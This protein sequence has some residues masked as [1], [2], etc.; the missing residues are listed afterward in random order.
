MV[1]VDELIQKLCDD[2]LEEM[3]E[4]DREHRS[5]GTQDQP[6]QMPFV[7]WSQLGEE[8]ERMAEGDRSSVVE[9]ARELL[10][11]A[12]VSLQA[13]EFNRVTY[14]LQRTLLRA[15]RI[16]ADE[17]E[18][19]LDGRPRVRTRGQPE[20]PSAS[21]GRPQQ[22]P[23]SRRKVSE[24]VETFLKESDGA[25]TWTASTAGQIKSA[26]H[27][28]VEIVGADRSI[29]GVTRDVV[30]D[31][32]SKAQRLPPRYTLTHKGKS[33][34]EVLAATSPDS[35]KV[36]STTVNQWLSYVSSMFKFAVNRGWIEQNPATGMKLPT[37][38]REKREERVPWTEGDLAAVFNAEYTK[39]TLGQ[40]EP[41]FGKYWVPLLCL[42]TGARL[43]E[44]AQLRVEDVEKV[45]DVHVVHVRE[46]DDQS[47]KTIA[48]IRTVPL[49]PTLLELGFLRHVDAMRSAGHDRLFPDL[50]NT[51]KNKYGDRVSKFFGRWKRK[52]GID[53]KKKVLHSFRNTVIDQLK[54]ADVQE[55]A[56]AE[57]V[58]HEN[59]SI[60]TGRYGAKLNVGRLAETVQ[61]LDYGDA[62]RALR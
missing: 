22:P 26:L 19:D 10:T 47:V 53:D 41:A 30:H 24:L 32:R 46:G 59:P 20:V 23:G 62:L 56:I 18:R 17:W 54:Q 29:G 21:T 35:P 34:S 12:D 3:I 5:S 61:K 60:T 36:A 38:R 14:E 50:D 9:E 2:Y 27:T 33:V 45:D 51:T 48:S 49:H 16:C 43:E 58:G 52:H 1:D 4:A 28:F 25:S 39:A 6:E 11:R 8:S 7:L 37:R 13:D 55:F 42:H 44:M 40:R 57:I 31:F 15:Y